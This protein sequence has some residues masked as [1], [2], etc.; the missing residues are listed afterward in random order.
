M[1]NNLLLTPNVDDILPPLVTHSTDLHLASAI[2][3]ELKCIKHITL[4]N[5][6]N[7]MCIERYDTKG[8]NNCWSASSVTG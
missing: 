8:N 2:S 3:N 6:P 1:S 4:L 5:I 7:S